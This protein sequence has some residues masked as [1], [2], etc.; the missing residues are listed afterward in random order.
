VHGCECPRACGGLNPAFRMLP[1]ACAR[2]NGAQREVGCGAMYMVMCARVRARGEGSRS[3][4]SRG[5]RL[6]W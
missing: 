2:G 3:E 4:P 1:L 6:V 5:G